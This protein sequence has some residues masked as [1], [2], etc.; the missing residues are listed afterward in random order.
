M[1]LVFSL[2]V[3]LKINDLLD[4]DDIKLEQSEELPEEEEEEENTED[5]KYRED[6][7]PQ[8]MMESILESCSVSASTRYQ[9]KY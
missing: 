7:E 2:F 8:D 9:Q 5:P 3:F 6:T 1:L 4:E